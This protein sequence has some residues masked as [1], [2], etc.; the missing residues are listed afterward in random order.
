MQK[1]KKILII[2]GKSLYRQELLDRLD[3]RRFPVEKIVIVADE[4]EHGEI[5]EFKDQPIYVGRIED[6]PEEG[7]DFAIV[8]SVVKE[9]QK[10]VELLVKAK[11]RFIDA[12][13]SLPITPEMPLIMPEIPYPGNRLPLAVHLPSSVGTVLILTCNALRPLGIPSRITCFAL[14]GVSN[15][16]SKSAMDELFEQ[17]QAIFSFREIRKNEFAGQIAF[18]ILP[19]CEIETLERRVHREVNSFYETEE[20]PVMLDVNWGSF[21]VGITGSLWMQFDEPVDID[22]AEK[23]LIHSTDVKYGKD[24]DPFTILDSVG[25]DHLILG[26]LRG[27]HEDRHLLTLRFAIDNLRK[28][29]STHLVQTLELFH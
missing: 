14:K 2:G 21:F 11:I 1:Q 13:H 9:M 12:S 6:M 20:I 22:H 5:H 7:Y 23:L 16:G 3:E 29:F 18:N 27:H 24:D 10:V 8:L 28:G 15:I 26:G 19:E 17:T 25:K 4:T